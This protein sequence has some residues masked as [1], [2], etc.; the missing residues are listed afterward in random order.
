MSAPL[1]RGALTR[2]NLSVAPRIE[3]IIFKAMEI[4]P[5]KRYQSA[6]AMREAI[7]PWRGF[8]PLPL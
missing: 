7:C 3:R 8:F 4:E 2:V 6:R 5:E 1:K